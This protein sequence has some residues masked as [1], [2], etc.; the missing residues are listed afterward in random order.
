MARLPWVVPVSTRT[1]PPSHLSGVGVGAGS[2]E[3]KAALAPYQGRTS[4]EGKSELR[5][6]PGHQPWLSCSRAFGVTRHPGWMGLDVRPSPHVGIPLGCRG[7]V[8]SGLG[9]PT[10]RG[11]VSWKL[12]GGGQS[13]AT[14]VPSVLPLTW[15]PSCPRGARPT[16]RPGA[17]RGGSLQLIGSPLTLLA[18]PFPQQDQNFPG[19]GGVL[20]SPTSSGDSAMGAAPP[21]GTVT[22][23]PVASPSSLSSPSLASLASGRLRRTHGL[24]S[25]RP[26]RRRWWERGVPLVPRQ[27]AR[28][29]SLPSPRGHFQQQL[30][31]AQAP[32][33]SGQVHRLQPRP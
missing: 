33:T 16:E 25:E 14:W 5:A 31:G 11:W 23:E 6:G 10:S 21:L 3:K 20:T 2:R 4:H 17:E 22:E 15:S 1:G 8:C 27:A 30:L 9:P 7:Q 12:G 26:A 18:T 29:P 32:P 28:P 24:H 13:V 19:A